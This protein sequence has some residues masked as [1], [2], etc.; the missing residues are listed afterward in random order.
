MAHP[1]VRVGLRP[2]AF[3]VVTIA[4]YALAFK[5]GYQALGAQ[6]M[7]LSLPLAA[8]AGWVYGMRMGVLMGLLLLP[9]NAL[10]LQWALA[11]RGA[12]IEMMRRGGLLGTG[13]TLFCGAVI[14]RLR[15]LHRRL[16]RELAERKRVEWRWQ[17]ANEQ[18]QASFKAQDEMVQN[19]SHELR[20]PLALI[21]GYVELM[22]EGALGPLT[23]EQQSAVAVLDRHVHRLRRMVDQLLALRGL[24][25][26]A[27]RPAPLNLH[28]LLAEAIEAWHTRAREVGVRFLLDVPADLPEIQADPDLLSQVFHNLL[29]NAIK[30]SPKGGT[31]RIWGR[32]QGRALTIAISDEGIGIPA[33]QLQW[34]FKRFYQVDGG[35]TRRFGGMGIGLALCRRIIELHQGQIWAESAGEGKGS[36][37]YISLPLTDPP[38]RH[39]SAEPSIPRQRRP[40][41]PIAQ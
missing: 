38:A 11:D 28:S 36:T 40:R 31:A 30:F 19:V 1:H 33:D 39:E 12:V 10:L 15:D 23:S 21:T 4:A 24:D 5:L 34:I 7:A 25:A 2:L 32:V 35:T 26:I 16:Q 22:K 8:A 6:V 27:L 14:G 9:T 13:I 29:E 20:T 37:F 18:L 41:S 3:L 17:R